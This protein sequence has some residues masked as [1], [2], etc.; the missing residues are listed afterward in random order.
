MSHRNQV[1]PAA[2]CLAIGMVTLGCSLWWLYSN[3]AVGSTTTITPEGWNIAELRTNTTPVITALLLSSLWTFI[4]GWV[5]YRRLVRSRTEQNRKEFG[6][7]CDECP[8][9]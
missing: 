4:S 3:N 6:D 5:F 9:E 2:I 8:T 7:S 1:K